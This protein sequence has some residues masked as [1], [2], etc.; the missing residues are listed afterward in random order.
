MGEK[1]KGRVTGETEELE[2]RRGGSTDVCTHVHKSRFVCF[3]VDSAWFHAVEQ[4]TRN[5]VDID[6]T[7]DGLVPHFFFLFPLFFFTRPCR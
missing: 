5:D 6:F 2:N 7:T 1:S 3:S 4:R